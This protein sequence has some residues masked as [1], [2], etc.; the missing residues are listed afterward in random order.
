MGK[1][2]TFW[3]LTLTVGIPFSRWG[4]KPFIVH[5]IPFPTD[6]LESF[7]SASKE[8]SQAAEPRIH[9]FLLAQSWRQELDQDTGLTKAKIAAREGIS[10]ARVT[11]VLNLL[12]LPAEIQA[13]LRTPPAPL[14]IHCFSE[15]SLRVLVACGDVQIQTS[16]WQNLVQE[17][18]ISARK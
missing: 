9:P 14:E 7:A 17:L 13:C 12:K 10:R 4:D 16:R 6:I 2:R 1:A 3:E 8:E 11:Q 18:V 5:P 15:R